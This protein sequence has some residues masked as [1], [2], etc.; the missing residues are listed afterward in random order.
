MRKVHRG[1]QGGGKE[2]LTLRHGA[3]HITE[4]PSSATK[5]VGGEDA[6]LDGGPDDKR[7][8]KRT[9]I[10]DGLWSTGPLYARSHA[11]FCAG[12]FEAKRT[13]KTLRRRDST[14]TRRKKRSRR[15]SSSWPRRYQ[16]AFDIAKESTLLQSIGE[17]WQRAGNARLSADR[18]QGV[19]KA[20]PQAPDR[21]QIE[22]RIKTI[23]SAQTDASQAQLQSSAPASQTPAQASLGPGSSSRSSFAQ[24]SQVPAPSSSRKSRLQASQVPP[25]FTS[26]GSS[27]SPSSLAQASQSP[28]SSFVSRLQASQVPA[29]A[30]QVPAQASQSRLKL[31]KRRLGQ[32]LRRLSHRP[33][34]CVWRVGFPLL[35]LSRWSQGG[36]VIGLGAQSRADELRRRTT[37]VVGDQPFT[38]SDSERDAYTSLMSEARP[39]TQQPSHC[40]LS[41][42]WPLR[43]PSRCLWSILSASPSQMRKKQA[44]V[45]PLLGPGTVGLSLVGDVMKSTTGFLVWGLSLSGSWAFCRPSR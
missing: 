19:R 8:E 15:E 42:V 29:L 28:G 38:Y 16:A 1:G 21:A 34:S 33:A 3:F 6:L 23:E 45:V 37:L 44:L 31:R 10:R 7:F 26:P 9:E 12:V 24:A 32:P 14:S 30:S 39:T 40:L 35:R 41:V 13:R 17:S 11:R 36:A 18:V 25:N 4:T 22:E 5:R 43:P 27:F 2:S 20:A